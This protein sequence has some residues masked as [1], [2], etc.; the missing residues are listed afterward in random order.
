M[1]LDGFLNDNIATAARVQKE[2]DALKATTLASAT[3]VS[4][5]TGKDGLLAAS[6]GN[7]PVLPT[8]WLRTIKAYDDLSQ[9]L[10][11]YARYYDMVRKRTRRD[12]IQAHRE[13]MR[14]LWLK[15]H[16]F[17]QQHETFLAFEC[18]L[19]SNRV[20]RPDYNRSWRFMDEHGLISE[21]SNVEKGILEK[22][23]RD[24]NATIIA[25]GLN[26]TGRPP[27]SPA[28][29]APKPG[30]DSNGKT[31]YTNSRA[32]KCTRAN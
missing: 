12:K 21:D 26:S 27:K 30:K 31:L 2:R 24:V 8:P 7:K 16:L 18:K 1:D 22:H 9:A 4:L 17:E 13:S 15:S 20:S 11:N 29:D 14:K 6:Q 28:G 3:D 23:V 5:T 32:G 10:D 25:N 19:R